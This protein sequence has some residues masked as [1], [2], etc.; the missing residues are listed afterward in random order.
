[1]LTLRPEALDCIIKT[2]RVSAEDSTLARIRS[3]CE[4]FE[5]SN[6]YVKQLAATQPRLGGA[7]PQTVKI[8]RSRNPPHIRSHT[9]APPHSQN[10]H[11]NLHTNKPQKSMAR[12]NREGSSKK[13]SC[14]YEWLVWPSSARL[15][16]QTNHSAWTQDRRQ[17]GLM[18]QLWWRTLRQGLP[19]GEPNG[20]PR[21]RCSHRGSGHHG[22][23]T[24]GDDAPKYHSAGSQ[25]D[26][27]N[28]L[29]PESDNHDSGS[30]RSDTLRV[31]NTTQIGKQMSVGQVRYPV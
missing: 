6:E 5:R 20:S 19:A 2:H 30:E 16:G 9:K 31:S 13:S 15:E 25:S 26:S 28:D 12:P 11:A 10:A 18:F 14:S 1:M 3:A 27:K 17:E 22:H 23:R 7:K 29:P 8:A 4:D 21:Q 24:M